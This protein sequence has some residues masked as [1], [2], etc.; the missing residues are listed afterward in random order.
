[1][2]SSFNTKASR[3]IRSRNRIIHD[4]FG[5]DLEIIWQVLHKSLPEL[6]KHLDNI[7]A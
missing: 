3:G 2:T 6:R 5:L 4:Y 7:Q 1:M